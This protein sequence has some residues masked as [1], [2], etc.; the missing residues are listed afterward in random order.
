MRP[1]LINPG[2]NGRPDPVYVELLSA[3]ERCLNFAH[4]GAAKVLNRNLM[5]HMWVTRGILDNGFP[6]F[7]PGLVIAGEARTSPFVELSRW[8]LA[9]HPENMPL[10]ASKRSQE[11]TYGLPHFLV[12]TSSVHPWMQS[13]VLRC[14]F[15]RPTARTSYPCTIRRTN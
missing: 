14:A 15:E 4:T 11:L 2:A 13:C 9:T 3:A 6:A 12:R 7:W 1:H 5:W 10:L 8:P